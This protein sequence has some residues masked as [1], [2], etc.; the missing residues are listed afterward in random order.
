MSGKMSVGRTRAFLDSLPHLHDTYFLLTLGSF[1]ASSV[2]IVL[3]QQLPGLAT[4]IILSVGTGLLFVTSF[5]SFFIFSYRSL[6]SGEPAR[7]EKLA[8]VFP[9]RI[10]RV[11]DN[12]LFAWTCYSLLLLNLWVY[13]NDPDHTTF[14]SYATGIDNIWVAWEAFWVTTAGLW[15]GVG[16]GDVLS[17]HWASRLITGMITVNGYLFTALIIG[18]IASVAFDLATERRESAAKSKR[19]STMQLNDS[20]TE[21]FL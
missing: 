16:F 5:Y 20:D 7:I 18:I 1:V 8:R 15:A 19:K 17:I 6:V 13:D 4:K 9:W 21:L 14:Y 2:L 11:V 10:L 12:I 3:V